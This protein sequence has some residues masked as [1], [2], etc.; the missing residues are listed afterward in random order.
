MLTCLA[1][2]AESTELV[3]N[4]L[5]SADQV[6][7]GTFEALEQLLC[8]MHKRGLVIAREGLSHHGTENV[9]W[10]E[11]PEV[12]ERHDRRWRELGVRRDEPSLS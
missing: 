9:T 5:E 12:R 7:L 4:A 10:W 8:D 1:D 11:T 3:C 6:S 2:D